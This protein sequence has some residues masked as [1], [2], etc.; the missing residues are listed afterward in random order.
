MRWGGNSQTRGACMTCTAMCGSWCRTGMIYT[1]AR[2]RLIR[3]DRKVPVLALLPVQYQE[4]T[5]LYEA[6]VSRATTQGQR[7]VASFRLMDVVSARALVW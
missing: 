5:V 7:Y 3:Q 2:R 4:L 6:R 1:Q